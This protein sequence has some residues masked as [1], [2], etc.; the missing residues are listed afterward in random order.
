MR[1]LRQLDPKL[2]VH[3]G[4]FLGI[5]SVIHFRVSFKS[6]KQME[7]GTLFQTGFFIYLYLILHLP[8]N[9][10]GVSN[11]STDEFF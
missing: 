9:V 8:K 10:A 2:V 11:F 7:L 5:S 1:S 6:T 3:S 4:E